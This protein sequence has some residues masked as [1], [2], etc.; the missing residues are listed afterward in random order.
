MRMGWRA[1]NRRQADALV[2]PHSHSPRV[3]LFDSARCAGA[4][5]GLRSFVH[6]HR[7]DGDLRHLVLDQIGSRKGLSSGVKSTEDFRT[8]LA[9]LLDAPLEEVKHYAIVTHVGD[10]LAVSF[11]G[12]SH[13]AI[14]LLSAALNYVVNV[15]DDIDAAKLQQ[16]CHSCED[17]AAHKPI[18]EW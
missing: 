12:L 5:A 3:H 8:A 15:R 14:K 16:D 9:G 18:T 13:D 17:K 7:T 11:C 1:A 4:S 10:D 2:L 6:I